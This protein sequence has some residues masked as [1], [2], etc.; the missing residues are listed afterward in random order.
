MDGH[1][2]WVND[3]QWWSIIDA[4]CCAFIDEMPAQLSQ[5]KMTCLYDIKEPVLTLHHICDKCVYWISVRHLDLLCLLFIV[6]RNICDSA[7]AD[8]L[9]NMYNDLL[10][11]CTQ[12]VVKNPSGPAIVN[13]YSHTEWLK[14]CFLLFQGQ[15]QSQRSQ[16]SSRTSPCAKA[17]YLK[18]TQ[19]K[20]PPKTSS[21]KFLILRKYSDLFY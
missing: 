5:F 13:I 2:K 7:Q 3:K 14:C 9:V 19:L 15:M 17:K 12:K 1:F 4:V 8:H 16:Y 10:A 18:C 21:H 6:K 20:N 11:V